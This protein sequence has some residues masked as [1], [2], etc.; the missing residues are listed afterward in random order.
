M[1]DLIVLCADKKIEA[2][3]AGLLDRPEALRIRRV[4]FVIN[5]H[6]QRDPGCY[7]QGAAFLR[8]LR[9]FFE[10]ALIVFDRSW[11]GAPPEAVDGLT[12]DLEGRLSRTWGQAAGA[13][14]IDPELE[15]WVWSDSPHVDAILGWEGRIPSLRAWLASNGLWEAHSP[16]PSNPKA[17]VELAIREVRG[18]WTAALCRRLAESVSVDRCRDLSFAKLRGLLT[19]WFVQ[20]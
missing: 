14:A 8:P 15:A 16:K 12:G 9:S 10:H 7:H 3:I 18:R 1:T 11:E 19:K 4:Q 13:V 5:V 17:A 2:T 6:P 20:G